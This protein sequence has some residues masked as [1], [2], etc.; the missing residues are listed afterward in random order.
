MH[1]LGNMRM[2]TPKQKIEE[3]L[4]VIIKENLGIQFV[5]AVEPP[6]RPE[7]G[8]YS[9]PVGFKLANLL[10]QPPEKITQ[11]LAEKLRST[12]SDVL[13]DVET[14]HGFLNIELSEELFHSILENCVEDPDNFIPDLDVSDRYLI[15]YVSANPTGP[16]NVAN[17]RAATVGS[18]LVNVLRKLG[19]P[20]DAEYYVNDSGGQIKAL[21]Q[22]IEYLLG[23]RKEFPDDGYRGEYLKEIAKTVRNVAKEKRSRT[24]VESILKSQME[25]LAEFGV[26]YDSIFY[27]SQF[28]LT[29]NQKNTNLED[30]SHYTKQVMDAFDKSNM[31]I[32]LDG[33]LYL[34]TNEHGDEKPR[35]LIRS[36]GEPTYF[37]YDLAYHLN[38]FDRGYT[39]LINLWGPDHQGHIKR[40]KIALDMLGKTLDD[41]RISGERLS[42]LIV[43]QVNLIKD[44]KRLIMSKRKGEYYTLDDLLKEVKRDTARFFFLMRSVSSPLD[45][46]LDLAKKL[47]NENPVYYVQYLHAR[48]CG[49]INHGLDKDI[50]P[51]PKYIHMLTLPEERMILRKITY[52]PDV[53]EAVFQKFEPHRLPY[54]LIELAEIFHSYYQ[55]VRVVTENRNQSSARLYLCEGVKNV[56]RVAL[57]LMGV[58]APTRM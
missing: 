29:P 40:M 47:S 24:V 55:K 48:I 57:D 37:L 19:I 53:L 26:N 36:T 14:I 8:D 5:P 54:Y 30:L 15:E 25:T 22:S 4:S 23:E 46:D 20:A 45:F 28:H 38:K 51:S 6:P 27:E 17:A 39:R 49:L 16:L 41:E 9:V 10:K 2:K 52:F 7:Y 11:H 18:T 34:K 42:V 31:T 58:S 43:Q 44:G 3:T 50:K 1:L 21:E 35:V 33:A 32:E 12:L 13:H 56:V